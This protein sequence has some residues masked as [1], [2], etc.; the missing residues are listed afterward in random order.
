MYVL[1]LIKICI[2]NTFSCSVVSLYLTPPPPIFYTDLSVLKKRI[3]ERLGGRPPPLSPPPLG[4]AP[5][6]RIKIVLPKILLLTLKC[7]KVCL[8]VFFI[9][10]LILKARKYTQK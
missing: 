6:A 2:M 1:D 4:Y 9:R 7:M 10:S 5:G 3:V 8:K